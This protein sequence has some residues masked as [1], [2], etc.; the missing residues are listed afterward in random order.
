MAVKY[1]SETFRQGTD[2]ELTAGDLDLENFDTTVM[3]DQ[4]LSLPMIHAALAANPDLKLFGS[5][6]SP[7]AWMKDNNDMLWQIMAI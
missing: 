5:P 1:C 4:N 7:P 3:Y 2:T 6:W